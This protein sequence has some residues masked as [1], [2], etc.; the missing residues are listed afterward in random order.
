MPSF[1]I[2]IK[3]RPSGAAWMGLDGLFIRLCSAQCMALHCEE[4]YR[5]PCMLHAGP[6]PSVRH[7]VWTRVPVHTC[8]SR[9][10]SGGW[11]CDPPLLGAC[12]RHFIGLSG[13]TLILS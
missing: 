2:I 9:I 7:P 13:L 10:A 1:L 6:C 11:G 3:Q 12:E 8:C 4:A 5:H